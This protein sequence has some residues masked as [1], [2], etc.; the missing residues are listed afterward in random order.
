MADP[1]ATRPSPADLQAFREQAV[2]AARLGGA[3]LRRM[4]GVGVESRFKTSG[5]DLV[6]AADLAS[7]RAVLAFIEERHP[8]HGWQ[9]E[10]A[11]IK[12]GTEPFRWVLDPLDGTSNFA[13]G[14]P[15][16]SVSLALMLGAQSIAG[17]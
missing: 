16:F 1:T 14:Y 12:Q 10:E 9:S 8:G 4:F 11:G 5:R 17:A 13:H 3:E 7:E 2:A 15:H 6:T